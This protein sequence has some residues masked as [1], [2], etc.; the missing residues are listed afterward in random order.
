MK[1]LKKLFRG[2]KENIDPENVGN[3]FG[4][5]AQDHDHAGHSHSGDHE[6]QPGNK[7]KCPMKCEGDK[8]YDAPGKCP[9]CNMNLT[10]VS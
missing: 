7:Y 5:G 8:T 6:N 2:A 4:H 9:V 1:S 3:Y 10:M